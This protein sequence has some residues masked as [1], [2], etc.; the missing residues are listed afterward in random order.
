MSYKPV[1]ESPVTVIRHPIGFRHWHATDQAADPWERVRCQM[2]PRPSARE[3]LALCD[4]FESRA[5][6]FG[7]WE[8][9]M[10]LDYLKGLLLRYDPREEPLP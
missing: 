3:F 4:R 6:R 9:T 8:E 5:L 2:A 7:P 1:L 10:L